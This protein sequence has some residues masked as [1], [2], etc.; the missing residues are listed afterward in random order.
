MSEELSGECWTN[1]SKQKKKEPVEHCV[2]P[3]DRYTAEQYVQP[4]DCYTAVSNVA[5][6]REAL[7]GEAGAA[8]SVGCSAIATIT[9]GHATAAIAKFATTWET[10]RLEAK[11]ATLVCHATV[12]PVGA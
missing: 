3:S 7:C 12:A 5:S 4:S 1:S 6:A 2:Q 11:A 10:I 9:L 8:Q